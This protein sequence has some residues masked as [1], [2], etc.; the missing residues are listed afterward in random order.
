MPV[1]FPQLSQPSVAGSR[2]ALLS[3]AVRS[4]GVLTDS[5]VGLDACQASCLVS[6]LLPSPAPR[7]GPIVRQSSIECMGAAAKG[8]VQWDCGRV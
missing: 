1:R 5:C 6:L 7:K 4:P 2:E 8:T 3:L